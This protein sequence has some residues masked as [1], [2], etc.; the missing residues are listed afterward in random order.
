MPRYVSFSYHFTRCDCT[1]EC[2]FGNL[3]LFQMQNSR[4]RCFILHQKCVWQSPMSDLSAVDIDTQSWNKNWLL[5]LYIIHSCPSPPLVNIWDVVLVWMKGDINTTVSVLHD[6]HMR[7]R[8][9]YLSVSWGWWDCP[10][11]WLSWAWWDWPLMW[12]S[13]TWW[14]WPLTWLTNHCHSVLQHCWL[15]P[16][17]RKVIPETTDN[18]PSGML[19]PIIPYPGQPGLSF[20]RH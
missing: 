2:Q 17:T 20:F 16:G 15:C 11:T 12:L 13:W 1:T 5:A 8:R 18:V 10:L 3:C 19:N 7:R 9:L 4:S 14:D 6:T